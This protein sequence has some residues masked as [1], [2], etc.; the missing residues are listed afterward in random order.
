MGSLYNRG[1][2][3]ALNHADTTRNPLSAWFGLEIDSLLPLGDLANGYLLPENGCF[4][5]ALFQP[6]RSQVDGSD[7]SA[8]LE[9]G[10]LL[11]PD[12]ALPARKPSG[13]SLWRQ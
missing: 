5:F 13:R 6:H 9:D 1:Y 2:L 4:C 3:P 7:V 12:W 10:S 8:A 11:W